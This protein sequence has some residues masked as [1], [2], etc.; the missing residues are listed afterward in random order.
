[1]ERQM[2]LTPGGGWDGS[3]AARRRQGPPLA[4]ISGYFA[5]RRVKE[6]RNDN[7]NNRSTA[8]E[9]WNG[10]RCFFCK[11][12][13]FEEKPQQVAG[14]ASS[15]IKDNGNEILDNGIIDDSVVMMH[16]YANLNMQI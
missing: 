10:A 3:K 15:T 6:F 9:C 16:K 2:E 11:Q 7:N 8:G 13:C 5:K 4:D 1:M 12:V 14:A